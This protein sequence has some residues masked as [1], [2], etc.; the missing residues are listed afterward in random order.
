MQQIVR[1]ASSAAPRPSVP[2]RAKR[3]LRPRWIP[4]SIPAWPPPLTRCAPADLVDAPT[5]EAGE[6]LGGALLAR[7]DGLAIAPIGVEMADALE[8][9]AAPGMAEHVASLE[10][11]AVLGLL[12][13]EI[14]GE[15]LARVADVEARQHDGLGALTA[16]GIVG[17]PGDAGLPQ[18]HHLEWIGGAGIAPGHVPEILGEDDAVVLTLGLVVEHRFVEFRELALLLQPGRQL[19]VGGKLHGAV[20]RGLDAALARKHVDDEILRPL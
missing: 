15:R 16:P 2:S 10:I 3:S 5:G 20:V 14:L 4:S 9:A 17:S 18:F 8:D 7:G 19:H 11:V 13:H 12:Q 1:R 6:G